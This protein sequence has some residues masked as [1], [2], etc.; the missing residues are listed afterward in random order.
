MTTQSGMNII[1]GFNAVKGLI[2]N[3]YVTEQLEEASIKITSEVIF[4]Y[5]QIH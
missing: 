4:R 3:K 5:Y 1:D 2:E